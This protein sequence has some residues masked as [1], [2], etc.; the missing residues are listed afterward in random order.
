MNEKY[1]WW[2]MPMWIVTAYSRR[3]NGSMF[4]I[5]GD[6]GF[7]EWI[8][9]EKEARREINRQLVH[10]PEIEAAKRKR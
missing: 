8:D 4:I 10:E 9:A 6:D 7:R 2:E 3:S 5:P 1:E